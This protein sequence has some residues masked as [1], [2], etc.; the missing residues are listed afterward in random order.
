MGPVTGNPLAA[1]EDLADQV[2]ARGVRSID[3]DIV[4]DDTWYVWQPYAA[5]WGIDDP[6]SDD[7]PPI[8]AL[9]LNDNALTLSVRPGA[10]AGDVAALTLHP[11]DGVLPH[12]QPRPHRRRSGASAAFTSTAFPAAATRGCGAPSRC[13]TAGRT[14]CSE[15]RIPPSTPPRH[16]APRCERAASPSGGAAVARAPLSQ[17]GRRPHTGCDP[18]R[19]VAGVELARR[20]SAALIEDLRVTDKVSQNLHAELALR[21]VGRARRNVGSFEAGMEEMK[22]LPGR[23]R[24][25]AAPT[26]ICGRLRAQPPQPGH[27]RDRGQAAALHVRFA[28]RATTGSRLLPVGGQD[29]T[30]ST[31]FGGTPAA[32]RVYAK[33]GSLSHVSALSGYIQR[34]DG[35]WVAF[36]ILVNNYQRPRHRRGAWRNGPHL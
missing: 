13:A 24:H 10:A 5:G 19:P 2:V 6:Q 1:I 17:P 28:G 14:C 16:C 30:L 18:P 22:A 4:G 34:R 7:G 25:R 9:T 27:S 32:G 26:T 11:A 31:R 15:S 33:T 3:G 8:S 35:N 12:R 23:S 29:G 20:V 21:A 36:S